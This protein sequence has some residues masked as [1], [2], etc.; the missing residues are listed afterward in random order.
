MLRSLLVVV[1]L[2]TPLTTTAT[3][4]ISEVAWMGTNSSA[5][6]EWIELH[7]SGSDAVSLEDWQL[8][9]SN[10][11]NI[12]LTGVGS[13]GAGGYAVL[14]RTD[15]D[16]APGTAFYIYTGSLTNS[17]ATLRLYDAAGTLVDQV[18]GGE[19]WETIGGNNTTKDTAQF[20]TSGWITAPATPGT[21]NA[22]EAAPE[23]ETKA[24]TA[25][26]IRG[27]AVRTPSTYQP[28][29]GPYA[30]SITAPDIAYVGQTV[31]LTANVSGRGSDSP[32]GRSV[33]WN[34]G[35]TTTNE[36]SQIT[37]TYQYPGTYIVFAE[38]HFRGERPTARHE[39]T[40]LPVSLAITRNRDGVVQLSN[41]APY[42]TNLSGYTVVAAD[43][44]VTLPEHTYLKAN[45]TVSLP[46]TTFSARRSDV[47]AVHD[48]YGSVVAYHLPTTV[49]R[50]RPA[51][52]VAVQQEV[53]APVLTQ[54]VSPSPPT[55][56]FTFAA[57][58]QPAVSA[59]ATSVA[60][61]SSGALTSPVAAAISAIPP[62]AATP[63]T[64]PLQNQ[65]AYL[66]LIG[67]LVMGVVALLARRVQV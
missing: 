48:A 35:D 3:V 18:A 44:T 25:P 17:G 62:A 32:V 55:A 7:N 36:G 60:A 50:S 20:S 10:S 6:D 37:H 41:T 31:A 67:L 38:A 15:D 61:T 40:V 33:T 52:A 39:I 53:A 8:R 65:W 9:D 21:V 45:A 43:E 49:Q 46:P 26:V 22:T 58:P 2:L 51:Q 19:N 54:R 4:Y 59:I 16:S 47:V 12:T 57:V 56:G 23:S 24:A 1:V 64:Q 66:G 11:L 34:L 13:L 42:E 5:N 27:N 28:P 63:S 14:E 30:I 29:T